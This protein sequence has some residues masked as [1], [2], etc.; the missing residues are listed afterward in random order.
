MKK[1][2]KN[3]YF[4]I[5]HLCAAIKSENSQPPF[6]VTITLKHIENGNKRKFR[7]FQRRNYFS[8]LNM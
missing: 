4:S 2:T 1:F 5:G 7:K 8:F 6:T 3:F